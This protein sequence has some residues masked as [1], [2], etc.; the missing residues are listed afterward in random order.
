MCWLARLVFQTSR[1]WGENCGCY[2]ILANTKLLFQQIRFNG[3]KAPSTVTA[4]IN[5]PAKKQMQEIGWLWFQ[6]ASK[7]T[8]VIKQKCFKKDKLLQALQNK[9][10]ANM[11]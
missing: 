8:Q 5:L 1:S 2:Q 10:K 11:Y 6:N 9:N 7:A 4:F 3:H